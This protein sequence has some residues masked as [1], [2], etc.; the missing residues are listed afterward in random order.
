[1]TDDSEHCRLPETEQPQALE[2]AEA[3]GD[4]P[5]TLGL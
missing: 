4:F 3:L 5:L 2:L 1:M